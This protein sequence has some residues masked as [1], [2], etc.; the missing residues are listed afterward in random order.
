MWWAS[1]VMLRVSMLLS[2]GLSNTRSSS[3]VIRTGG[4]AEGTEA[5]IMMSRGI[6]R[7]LSG[8]TEV[9]GPCGAKPKQYQAGHAMAG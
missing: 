1:R 3:A 7:T 9:L 5:I 8:R 6:H 2:L 4:A